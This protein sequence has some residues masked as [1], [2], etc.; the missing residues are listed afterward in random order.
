MLT[1]DEVQKYSAI[2]GSSA[3]DES[4]M[5][6]IRVT[7]EEVTKL[8]ARAQA[9][10][11][12]TYNKSYWDV[13]YKVGQKVWLRVKN[14]RIER[15]SQK[16]DC[17]R[18]SPYRIIERIGK[19]AYRLDLPASLQIHNVF[20]VSS[21]SDHN[22]RVGEESPEPQPILKFGNT[23]W[24]Q[25]LPHGYKQIRQT[26]LYCN[27][28]SHGRDTLS[29]LGNQRQIWSMCTSWLTSSTKTIPKCLVMSDPRSATTYFR[30]NSVLF[31][32]KIIWNAEIQY[33]ARCFPVPV[34]ILK[35]SYHQS[36]TLHAP[37]KL[38]GRIRL[39]ELLS[40]NILYFRPKTTR[41]DR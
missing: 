32:S 4:L 11:A 22:P 16:L 20:H 12:H 24:K 26:R 7:R 35:K 31:P 23:R 21:L 41:S 30:C 40:T 13:E 2:R 28:K 25:F 19:V 34:S 38:S 10:Q 27:T 33:S 5:G 15:P 14:I 39:E 37:S 36:P 18:Y 9:Y 1:L 8:L 3:E 29:W 17:Q 6:R